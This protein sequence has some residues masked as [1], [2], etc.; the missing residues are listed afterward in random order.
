M[1][2]GKKA[3]MDSFFAWVSICGFFFFRYGGV[4]FCLKASCFLSFRFAQV[5]HSILEKEVFDNEDEIKKTLTPK[6]VTNMVIGLTSLSLSMSSWYQKICSR[7]CSCQRCIEMEVGPGC[8]KQVRL[9]RFGAVEFRDSV[10]RGRV[11]WVS[12]YIGFF[13]YCRF[14]HEHARI[15]KQIHGKQD[16]NGLYWSMISLQVR[17]FR[18]S[19]SSSSQ[20]P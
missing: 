12:V 11:V 6:P 2:R 9:I 20:S 17:A 14:T 15:R 16:K 1:R 13:I 5:S 10:M 7:C 19:K 8:W 18:T 3:S 4:C